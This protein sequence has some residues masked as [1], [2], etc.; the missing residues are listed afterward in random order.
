LILP[1]ILTITDRGPR[2]AIAGAAGV[3]LIG[4][5]LFSKRSG[6]AAADEAPASAE[7]AA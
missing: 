1:A 2:L 3:I 7:V 4:A 6:Q 5:V